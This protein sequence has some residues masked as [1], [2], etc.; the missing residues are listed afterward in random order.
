MNLLQIYFP[1]YVVNVWFLVSLLADLAVKIKFLLS[2]HYP[3]KQQCCSHFLWIFKAFGYVFSE[4]LT[5]FPGLDHGYLSETISFG[6]LALGK[7]GAL[8]Y[9]HVTRVSDPDAGV[10]HSKV[11]EIQSTVPIFQKRN[12][13]AVFSLQ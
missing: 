6:R 4:N 2:T 1:S 7:Q 8:P 3:F 9:T 11:T 12:P 13:T 5:N 10:C